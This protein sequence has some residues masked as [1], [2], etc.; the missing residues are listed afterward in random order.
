MGDLSAGGTERG[1]RSVRTARPWS[2]PPGGGLG[3]PDEG[4]VTDPDEGRAHLTRRRRRGDEP[5]MGAPPVTG[6]TCQCAAHRDLTTPAVDHP[7]E[8]IA[9]VAQCMTQ[10]GTR[11]LRRPVALD[12]DADAVRPPPP[13]RPL[14]ACLAAV[15]PSASWPVH[16][17]DRPAA[18]RARM[19]VDHVAEE[20]R[21]GE[22]GRFG[23]HP[24]HRERRVSHRSIGPTVPAPS[25]VGAS[26]TSRRPTS[27]WRSAPPVPGAG[28]SAVWSSPSLRIV[29]TCARR[30]VANRHA[31]RPAMCVESSR[32]STSP[33]HE[34]SPTGGRMPVMTHPAPNR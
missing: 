27:R 7:T 26:R 3:Q 20:R 1:R 5:V 17:V 31:A 19:A 9:A 30:V 18:R 4:I 32:L 13:V 23:R 10:P 12:E 29:T 22:M 28:V 8:R 33:G 11:L 15:H 25:R 14:A 6:R 2:Q 34:S 21:A 16:L 24:A